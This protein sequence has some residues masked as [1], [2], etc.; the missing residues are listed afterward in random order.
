M[1]LNIRVSL[2]LV[3]PALL[4][5]STFHIIMAVS[6]SKDGTAA[7]ALFSVITI[8]FLFAGYYLAGDTERN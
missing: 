4:A 2:P 8:P 6:G 1:G 7:G 5:I 3:F